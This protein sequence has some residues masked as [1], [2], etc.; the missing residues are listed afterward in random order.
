M[1]HVIQFQISK[2]SSWYT[3]SAAD[4]AIVTQAKTFEELTHNMQ[5]AVE[6]YFHDENPEE[7][8]Y[9][10]EPSLFANFEVPANA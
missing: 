5:E 6:V 7:L 9:V 8:G 1:K 2:N 3:A 10:P 4:L